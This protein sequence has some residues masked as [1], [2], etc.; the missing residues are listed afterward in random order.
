MH[1]EV[2]DLGFLTR[3]FARNFLQLL[4]KKSSET[5]SEVMLEF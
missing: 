5:L 2:S 1:H 4:W 3:N